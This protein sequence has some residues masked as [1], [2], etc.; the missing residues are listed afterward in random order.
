MSKNKNPNIQIFPNSVCSSSNF[1][2]FN[3]RDNSNIAKKTPGNK[4]SKKKEFRSESQKKFHFERA[5]YNSKTNNKENIFTS[6]EI[7]CS[8]SLKSVHKNLMAVKNLSF[9]FNY[10]L[11]QI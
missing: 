8:K 7:S 1:I 3:E 10:Y 9:F 6:P 5:K 4:E 2:N 11:I